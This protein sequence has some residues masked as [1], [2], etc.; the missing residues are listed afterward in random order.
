M[1]LCPLLSVS[2]VL[3]VSA[4]LIWCLSVACEL[5]VGEEKALKSAGGGGLFIVF[6]GAGRLRV[7]G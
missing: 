4:L 1:Y 2:V 5:F 6:Q 7:R 3:F